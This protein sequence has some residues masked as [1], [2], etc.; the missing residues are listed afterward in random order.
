MTKFWCTCSCVSNSCFL[1]CI[2]CLALGLFMFLEHKN[3]WIFLP[4]SSTASEEFSVET[5]LSKNHESLLGFTK[6]Y[7]LQR[8]QVINTQ[9]EAID[10]L[11]REAAY[12]T[13]S[14]AQ[15]H[16]DLKK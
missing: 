6:A 2:A 15:L 12:V 10:L 13:K 7:E 3:I 9:W 11:N 16:Q 14:T 1:W 5:S 4:D 8:R